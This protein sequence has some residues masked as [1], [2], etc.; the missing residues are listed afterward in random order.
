ML[1][2]IS[3]PAGAGKDYIASQIAVTQ[4]GYKE[5]LLYTTRSPRPGEKDGDS[6][7]FLSKDAFLQKES[8]GEL[9]CVDK[10][11]N[12]RFYA[13]SLKEI[14]N[15]IDSEEDHI[16]VCTPKTL[17]EIKKNFPDRDILSFYITAN[18]QTRA[19]RYISRIDREKF[20]LEDL[21]EL[22]NRFQMD[23]GKFDGFE[24]EVD[25]VID[26]SYDNAGA[27]SEIIQIIDGTKEK[28][29]D[30]FPNF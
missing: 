28:D 20:S 5:I 21:S 14:E 6:Y 9:F 27:E 2:T 10:Y 1:I 16:L 15:A 13:L 7:H 30:G 4:P 12:D 17:K 25:Y 8:L 18:M 11:T 24:K 3:G 23:I 22:N 19:K 29:Y 26:N